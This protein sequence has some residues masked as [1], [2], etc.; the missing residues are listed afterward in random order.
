MSELTISQAAE[1]LG[2]TA[3][4]LRHWDDIGLLVPSYR[5]WGDYRL[6]T[7]ADLDTALDILVFRETGLP[8]KEI[9]A[10]IHDGAD[11]KMRLKQQREHIRS[12]LAKLRRMDA[13]ISSMMEQDYSMTQKIDA[14]GKDW[15]EY[16]AE[17]EARWGDTPEW[18][19]SQQ[20]QRNMK[21]ADWATAKQDMEDFAAALSDAAERDV[22]PGSEEAKELVLRH[23]AQIA[24]WYECSAEKQVCLA[25]MYVADE[26]FH[27][28]YGGHQEYLLELVEKQAEA[29]G[30]DL[31][32]VQWR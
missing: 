22:A 13:A 4:T 9:A 23:R 27:A 24:Q 19:Q 10:I 25:R 11:P 28:A 18:E 2:V 29:E 31:S 8:L 26:R 1:L 3:R 32:A 14:L 6:Y 30:V 20:R 5:T 16:A 21:P 15:H 17:A 12:Q 7:E